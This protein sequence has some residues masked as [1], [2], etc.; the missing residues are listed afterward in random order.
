MRLSDIQLK[1]LTTCTVVCLKDQEE[2]DRKEAQLPVKSTFSI[3]KYKR[4]VYNIE[5]QLWEDFLKMTA[6]ICLVSWGWGEGVV[7]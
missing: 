4:S 7:H 1:Q 6:C 2:E 3:V 5:M